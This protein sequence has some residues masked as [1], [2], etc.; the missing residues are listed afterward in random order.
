MA[1]GTL[2]LGVSNLLLVAIAWLQSNSLVVFAQFNIQ[3]QFT[4]NVSPQARA[5]FDIAVAK[6]QSVITGDIGNNIQIRQGQRICGQPPAPQAFLVDDLHIFAAIQPIDGP[7]RVLGSAGP[8]GFDNAGRIRLGSMRFDE[9]DV[10]NL[11]ATNRF[12]ATV[13]ELT[14]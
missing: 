6:W 13:S 5:S 2:L 4:T 8:C 1:K 14:C 12:T 11:I 10:A 3:I 7:G 9:A